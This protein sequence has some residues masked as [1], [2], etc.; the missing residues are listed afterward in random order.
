MG[1]MINVALSMPMGVI[2]YMLTEKIIL[3]TILDKQFNEKVQ[4][5]FIIGFV[6]GLAYFALAMT[7]FSDKGIFDNQSVQL[8]FYGAGFFLIMN[9]AFFSWDILD[10]NTKMMILAIAMTGMVIWSY[11]QNKKSREISNK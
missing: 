6:A 9:S 8:A 3:N 7:A 2:I 10:E 5:N 1:Y 4:A 11:S